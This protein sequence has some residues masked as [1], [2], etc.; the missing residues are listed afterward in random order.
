MSDTHEVRDT[1]G[2]VAHKIL[3]AM[4]TVNR[5]SETPEG[6]VAEMPHGVLHVKSTKTWGV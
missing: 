2:C 4:W 1:R 6:V 3:D 5:K